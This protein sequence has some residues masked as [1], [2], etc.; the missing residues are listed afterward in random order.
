VVSFQVKLLVQKRRVAFNSLDANLALREPVQSSLALSEMASYWTN[1][2]GTSIDTGAALSVAPTQPSW[3]SPSSGGNQ[4]PP[5]VADRIV[6]VQIR[7]RIYDP[8][9]GQTRQNTL[10]QSL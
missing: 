1:T 10:V 5:S 2:T 8:A 9:S 7:L 6:G 4:D 3:G